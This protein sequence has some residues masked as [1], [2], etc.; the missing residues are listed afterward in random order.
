MPPLYFRYAFLPFF[1]SSFFLLNL[2]DLLKTAEV[3][4]HYFQAKPSESELSESVFNRSC[5]ILLTADKSS[6]PFLNDN[7]VKSVVSRVLPQYLP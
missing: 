3:I 5:S 6:A 7:T 1:R 2:Q 4:L